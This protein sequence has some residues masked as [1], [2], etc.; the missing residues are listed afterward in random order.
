[1]DRGALFLE[2]PQVQRAERGTHDER[3]ISSWALADVG[4]W[5]ACRASPG[6]D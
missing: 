4:F 5:L 1:M 3:I 2:M 6:P